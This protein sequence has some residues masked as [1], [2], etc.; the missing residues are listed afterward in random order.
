MVAP[1]PVSRTPKGAVPTGEVPETFKAFV[2]RFPQLAEAHRQIG[3]T[4]DQLG[5]LDEKSRRLIKIGICIGAGLETA[6]C[7]HVRRALEQGVSVGEL[8]QAVLLAMNTVGFPR[9][10]MHWQWLQQQAEIAQSRR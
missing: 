4:V 10:V 3:K 1:S 5:P 2:A 6:F 8:E 9:T 7:S